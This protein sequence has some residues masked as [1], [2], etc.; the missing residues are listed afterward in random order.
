M[1]VVEVIVNSY[2]YDLINVNAPEWYINPEFL[3]ILA[4]EFAQIA[5]ATPLE[6]APG[7]L[8]VLEDSLA[9]DL[10]FF[11]TLPEVIRYVWGA[12]AATF[13]KDGCPPL[14][15]F[16][17]GTDQSGL[18][19]RTQ[20]YYDTDHI[21]LPQRVR[22]AYRDGYELSHIGM[23]C[24]TPTP[25]PALVPRAR[26]YMLAIEATFTC[27]FYGVIET[28]MDRFWSDMMPWQRGSVEWLPLCTHL[29]LSEGVGEALSFTAEQLDTIAALRRRRAADRAMKYYRQLEGQKL[30]D[31]L[32][33]ASAR[34]Q[35]WAAAHPEQ[36]AATRARRV[37]KDK[38]AKK[39]FCVPC[40]LPCADDFALQCHYTTA[41]HGQQVAIANGAPP[42]QRS[43]KAVQV[44]AAKNRARAEKRYYCSTCDHAASSLANLNDHKT[45]KSHK[46]Q[47]AAAATA[48]AAAAAAVWTASK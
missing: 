25:L 29:S 19:V 37:A 30:V 2:C 18:I 5:A 46:K 16:G 43:L 12:Y 36:A 35:A 31:Y 40:K 8:A 14:I 9:P 15:Y 28:W 41:G 20:M 4:A 27:I 26:L 1:S 11:Q 47:E 13:V 45:S 17:T 33:N 22:E 24:W 3:A 44:E 39:Y 10:D 21:R 6:F 38:A 42:V 48:A 34:S 32:A 23:L 7:L